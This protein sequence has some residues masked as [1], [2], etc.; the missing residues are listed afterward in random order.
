MMRKVGQNEVISRI[1]V[2]LS[3]LINDAQISLLL[4]IF[5]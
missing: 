3:A 4:N 2:I 5:I 1:K